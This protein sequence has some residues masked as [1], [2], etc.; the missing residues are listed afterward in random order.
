M[1]DFKAKRKIERRGVILRH[2]E[3]CKDYTASADSLAT[4]ANGVGVPTYYS[5]MISD[6]AWLEKKGYV[7]LTGDDDVVIVEATQRG[8][9]LARDEDRDD[10]VGLPAARN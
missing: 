3:K 10:N 2:L 8:L 4:V 5:D 7:I 9:R 1:M 6:L